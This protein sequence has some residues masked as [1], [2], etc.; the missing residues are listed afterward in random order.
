MD[1]IDIIEERWTLKKVEV[2]CNVGRNL[3]DLKSR[4][5]INLSESTCWRRIRVRAFNRMYI[6]TYIRCVLFIS[7]DITN[8]IVVET[9]ECIPF[10]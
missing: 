8:T 6:H 10:L 4:F 1:G 9:E 7:N 5:I 2:R 3:I